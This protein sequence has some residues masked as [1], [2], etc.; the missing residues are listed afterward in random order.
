MSRSPLNLGQ[1]IEGF[2]IEKRVS[3]SDATLNNYH[4]ALDKL[5]AHVPPETPLTEITA[6]TVAVLLA[7]HRS[8]LSGASRLN[9]HAAC[10]SLWTWA[11]ENGYIDEHIMR[12]VPMPKREGKAV[13][14]FTESD[15]RAMLAACDHSRSYRRTGQ[16][17]CSHSRPTALRDRAIVLTMLDTGIRAS[18]LCDLR[19][20][21]LDQE[22]Q[23]ITIRRGKGS[24]GRVIMI[25]NRTN[26]A[27]WLYL[28]RSNRSKSPP[29]EPLFIVSDSVHEPLNRWVLHRLIHRLGVRAGIVPD[30]HPHRFR[31]TFAINALRNGCDIYSLKAM[32]GH[33]SLQMVQTYLA[34]AQTDVEDA[35]RRSS[36]VDNW[37]L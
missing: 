16:R 24:K 14:P 21:D 22:N 23:R 35:H 32:L 11:T 3:L 20:A 34:L 1:A 25:G 7:D 2:F 13:I 8:D 26:R 30:A 28:A 37:H 15:I 4:W 17:E 36:P 9:I 6:E 5:T 31:H 19:C 18:E 33:A 12:S 10:S 29:A 27:L